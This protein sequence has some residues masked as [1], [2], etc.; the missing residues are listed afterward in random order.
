MP[1]AQYE[2]EAGLRQPL[3]SLLDFLQLANGVFIED[4]TNAL[5]GGAAVALAAHDHH[6]IE[7]IDLAEVA[8]F[9][10]VILFDVVGDAAGW[11]VGAG[12]ELR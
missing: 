4:D 10:E 8:P 12:E 3:A 11:I 6:Q 1:R 5:E 9:D 2:G 7:V